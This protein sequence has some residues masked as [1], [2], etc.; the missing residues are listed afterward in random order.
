MRKNV[1]RQVGTV[2]L[3]LIMVFTS[4]IAGFADEA[5]NGIEVAKP[6][7]FSERALERM[8]ES[9]QEALEKAD[10]EFAQSSG[11]IGSVQGVRSSSRS[12][13]FD[14]AY[15]PVLSLKET[16][17]ETDSF[18]E[19]G[20]RSLASSRE[21]VGTRTDPSQD[22]AIPTI[23]VTNSIG[24]SGA[25]EGGFS[26]SSID[27]LAERTALFFRFI[28]LRYLFTQS[29]SQVVDKKLVFVG[30]DV[31]LQ[32]SKKNRNQAA[33]IVISLSHKADQPNPRGTP[34]SKEIELVQVLP[35][36]ETYNVL[37]AVENTRNIGLGIVLG[38]ISLGSRNV[39]SDQHMYL[40]QDVDTVSFQQRREDKLTFGWTF[41]PVLGRPLVSP[42]TRRVYALLAVPDLYYDNSFAVN[43]TTGWKECD[44]A[45]G[46]IGNRL[47]NEAQPVD[48]GLWLHQLRNAIPGFTFHGNDPKLKQQVIPV[49]DDI[50]RLEVYG[51]KFTRDMELS[52]GGQA[53][54]NFSLEEVQP[55]NENENPDQHA[56]HAR[57]LTFFAPK[58]LVEKSNI[59]FV[60]ND[61]GSA[62]TNLD[63]AVGFP[64]PEEP[65]VAT[66]VK[67]LILSHGARQEQVE[68]KSNDKS[69]AKSK[70]SQVPTTVLQVRGTNLKDGYLIV[71]GKLYPYASAK[72]KSDK[73]LLYEVDALG[74]KTNVT[75]VDARGILHR[76]VEQLVA[77]PTKSKK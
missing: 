68:D 65:D 34:G 64:K 4:A 33:E 10:P 53:I 49:G 59:L 22:V 32:P 29:V 23:N 36:K 77:S 21:R 37:G 5:S 42:G 27:N 8:L 50:F 24:T 61:W 39:S 71:A 73:H 6:L 62:Q 40:V 51:V 13:A 11:N 63:N 69:S 19:Q 44:P 16:I 9:A 56:Q 74:L 45:T 75:F 3:T 48:M 66:C 57:K 20:V 28:N 60:A 70:S 35:L 54:Q 52:L 46:A 14:L 38:P 67:I 72:H 15:K 12:S 31:S 25:P 17:T 18:D 76:N 7:V 1:V 26:L 41:R 47:L 30:F 58:R 55:C 2:A 43:V